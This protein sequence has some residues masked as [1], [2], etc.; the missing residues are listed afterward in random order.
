MNSPCPQQMG[1]S[2]ISSTRIQPPHQNVISDDI[3]SEKII[4]T[5]KSLKVENNFTDNNHMTIITESASLQDTKDL[6]T[7]PPIP[8]KT[9]AA[10]SCM[11]AYIFMNYLNYY[12]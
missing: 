12:D 6:K 9:K 4:K 10:E 2:F 11:F 7:P 8:K 5:I 1:S 3:E